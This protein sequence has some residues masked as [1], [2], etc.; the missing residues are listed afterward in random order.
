MLSF[1]MCPFV[2]LLAFFV[3]QLVGLSAGIH[4]N[5]WMYFHITWMEDEFRRRE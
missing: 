4:K 5:Y 1:R 3:S 2:C